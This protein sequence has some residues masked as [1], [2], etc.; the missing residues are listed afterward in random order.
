MSYFLNAR[1]PMWTSPHG[2]QRIAVKVR[3]NYAFLK[4]PHPFLLHPSEQYT[5]A[6]RTREDGK[7]QPAIAMIDQTCPNT[8]KIPFALTVLVAS[9]AQPV[10]LSLEPRYDSGTCS[11]TYRAAP[12]TSTTRIHREISLFYL[13]T[14]YATFLAE[15]NHATLTRN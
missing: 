1:Y 3:S 9:L 11:T 7:K 10:I 4:C 14:L 13:A 2:L 15:I 6:I 8:L 12:E 5:R